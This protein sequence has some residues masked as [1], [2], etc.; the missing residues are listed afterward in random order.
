M[1]STNRMVLLG[2]FSEERVHL[3]AIAR[4]R[5]WLVSQ[6]YDMSEFALICRSCRGSA[7]FIHARTIAMH[8][9]DALTTVQR[10]APE[11]RVVLCAGASAWNSFP[12]MLESGAFTVLMSPLAEP[13]VRLVLEFVSAQRGSPARALPANRKISRTIQIH[14]A[15]AA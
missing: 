12:E 11:A 2:D 9:K 13:E 7:I 10:L 15:G 8:W 6:A 5:N 3:A 14:R 1:V 4:E